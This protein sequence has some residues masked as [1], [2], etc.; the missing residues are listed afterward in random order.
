MQKLFVDINA[1]VG[2]GIGNE[3]LLIPYLGSCNIACGG[4]A[5]TESSMKPVLEL[6]KAYSVKVGAHPSFPDKINF[7]RQPMKMGQLDFSKSITQQILSLKH[8]AEQEGLSLNHVK[9]HGALYNQCA[10]DE[11]LSAW[12]VDVVLQI[13]NSLKIYTPYNSALSRV[14]KQSGLEVVE[15][16]FAD[17]N[18]N[19]DL[20]LVSRQKSNAI[21]D[22]KEAVLEHVLYMLKHEKVRPIN[23]VGV[24]LKF[25]TLCV[26]GDHKNS[27]DILKYL[28]DNLKTLNTNFET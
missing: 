25:Q 12:L 2:E 18:Y 8:L 14:A 17:R 28:H 4:H 23:G 22:E 24:P 26:H 1:D 15:E 11:N 27:V 21:I 13:D 20:S 3:A 16:A 5:G 6:A 9:P 10:K 7:G 19:D